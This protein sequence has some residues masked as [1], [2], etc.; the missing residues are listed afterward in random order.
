MGREM[1]INSSTTVIVTGGSKGI[2]KGIAKAFAAKG[3]QV[4]TVSR[5]RPE[6]IDDEMLNTGASSHRFWP[7]DLT[8]YE[9]AKGFFDA[10]SS[11]VGTPDVLINNAGQL[12]GGLL[13]EQPPEKIFSM[14]QVN[15]TTLILLTRFFL[16]AMLE[17]RSGKIVN[18]ASVS[19]KMFFPCASTYA[20]SK[21]GVV[22]FTES[23]KQELR[24]TGVSTLLLIT[25]GVKTEMYDEIHD[26]YG[27]HLDLDFLKSI[28]V[29]EWSEKVL[30]AI[31]SD[32]DTL[33]PTGS[34]RVGVNLAHHLPGVFEGFIS[35]KF[36]R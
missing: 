36:H 19:G 33:W 26:L 5:S 15:L 28:P 20:A 4:H 3:A 17:R 23:L 16:P 25:A 35:K 18:N 27:G 22:G 11:E 30:E 6:G 10:F 7:V 1:R 14:L 13:E 21:A 9:G 31:E 24:D 34:S 2:G 32:Q 12:T 8:T 29:A